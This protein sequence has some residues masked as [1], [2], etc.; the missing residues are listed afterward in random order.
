[1]R[2]DTYVY[3]F[4]KD[5]TEGAKRLKTMRDLIKVINKQRKARGQRLYV[6]RVMGRNENRKHE[7]RHYRQTIPLKFASR[8]DVYCYE[9]F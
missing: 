1:M 6:I 9:K 7:G 3:T 4:N 2:T 8:F 5:D